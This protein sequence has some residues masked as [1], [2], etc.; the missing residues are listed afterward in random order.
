MATQ[1][2][3]EGAVVRERSLLRAVALP[4]EHG[5]WGLTLEPGLLGMLLAPSWAG[6]AIALA[7]LIAFLARTPLKLVA[8]DVRRR[9]WA[10]RS[11]VALGVGG[12]ELIAFGGAAV[13]AL[14]SAGTAWL[15]PVAII[16]PLIVV[17]VWYDVRSRGRRLVPELCGAV[18][19]AGVT[20]S[21]VLAGE[22]G[23]RLAAGGSMVLAARSLAAIPFVRV[24]V[25]RLRRGSSAVRVG[26]SDAA[27][28][29]AL[30]V[31]AGA[32]VV[33]RRA[34]GG[35]VL[36]VVAAGLHMRWVRQPP[37][38]AKVLGVRQMLLGLCVV[39]GTAGSAALL[40]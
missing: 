9:Q 11:K 27:Q 33:A 34:L 23:A 32:A 19:M 26:P 40:T 39:A 37:V 10:R 7:A 21:V 38:A 1:A 17:E 8:V 12:A 29:I 20:A 25:Q 14:W 15:V 22:G 35:L 5:G 24:Q 4:S 28:V 36:L 18:G 30:I 3:A 13:A 6:L 31:G 2:G 16:T